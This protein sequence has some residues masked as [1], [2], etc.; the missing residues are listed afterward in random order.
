[1]L[2]DFATFF[3]EYNFLLEWML[4]GSIYTKFSLVCDTFKVNLTKEID[5]GIQR[6]DVETREGSYGYLSER[7]I[8]WC[9]ITSSKFTHHVKDY[10]SEPI[11]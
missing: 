6:A 11:I 7:R 9:L 4:Q 5:W 8:L 10:K 3:T 1:M 2:D